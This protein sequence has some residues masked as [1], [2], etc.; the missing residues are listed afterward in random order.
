MAIGAVTVPTY[1]TN[2]VADHAHILRDSGARAAIASTARLAGA[3][4]RPPGRGRPGPAGLP[5]GGRPRRRTSW[6]GLTADPRRPGHAGGGGRSRSRRGGSPASS[7]PPAP[8]AA[9]KGVMLPHR[10]MLANRAGVLPLIRAA[11]PRRR[12]LLPLL[13]AALAR[14]RAHGGRL[15]AALLRDRGGLL[16]RRRPPGRR[17]HRDRAAL[18]TAVPRLFEVLRARILAGLE[19]EKPC[20]AEAVRPRAGARPA[21]HGRP[22]A[23]PPGAAAGRRAGPAGPRQGPRPLRG[24]VSW[25]IVSGGARLDPDLSG[26]FLAL[27]HERA[28]GLRPD[29]GRPGHLA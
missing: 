22:A 6:A 16:P 12:R 2:T 11:R 1:T 29:R 13:P 18:V 3:C 10:A 7:T 5:G 24:Q 27:G 8:A 21:A 23:G 26:F 19:K 17:V 15:P 28:A 4:G 20:Q 14:L 25:R 9:P